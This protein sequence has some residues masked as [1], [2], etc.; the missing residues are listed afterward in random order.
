MKNGAILINAEKCTE[1][2]FCVPSCP[3]GMI[4]IDPVTHVAIKCD[5]C[6]G[7]PECANRCPE[8]A[9]QFIDAEKATYYRQRAFAK[10]FENTTRDLSPSQK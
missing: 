8:K 4:R 1:C 10:L 6:G 5:L 9:L 3:I 2:G 7:D